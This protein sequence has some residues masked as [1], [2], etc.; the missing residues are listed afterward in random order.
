MH[1]TSPGNERLKQARRVRDGRVPELLFVE[2]LRLAE[3]CLRSGTV[4]DTCFAAPPASER[5]ARLLHELEQAGVPVLLTAPAALESLSATVHS[6]GV[7][8]LARRPQHDPAAFA[9]QPCTLLLALD[10]VQDPGNLGTLLRTA[11]AAG[12]EAVLLLPG[13]ADA[14]A[15]KV[16]RSSM[17]SAFRLPVLSEVSAADLGRLSAEQGLRLVAAAGGGDLE[18]FDYDWRQPTLLVLGNEANGVS[19][20]LLAQC[21]ARLRI[22]M[23]PG[24]ESLNVATAGAALL[25]EAVRQRR[26]QRPR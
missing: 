8:L 15:P 5:A 16:L 11:E 25:F 20:P 21:A 12:V 13:C 22:P 6:Q 2:G 1:I 19:E 3:D 17:G 23:Q 7:I 26:P 18:H 10:R 14:F 4:I 9:R 24:V